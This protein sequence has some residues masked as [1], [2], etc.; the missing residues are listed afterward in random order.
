MVDVNVAGGEI[1]ATELE[2]SLEKGNPSSLRLFRTQLLA[3]YHRHGRSLPWRE[4]RD[5]YR[6]WVSEVMLQQTQVATV[7]PYYDR[8]LEKFPSVGDLANAP[9]ETVLR[10]WEGLGYYRRARQ[11][12]AAAKQIVDVHDGAFPEVLAEVR[13]LP[14]IGRYTAGAILSFAFEQ[15]VPILE[16]NTQRLFARLIA[17]EEIVTRSSAQERL[18]TFAEALLPDE[19]PG[20]FN[21]ALMELGSQVCIPLEPR[22]DE[23]PVQEFCQGR[24]R[25]IAARLPKKVA[26]PKSEKLTEAAVILRSQNRVLL[27]RCGLGERWEG[28]W[29]FPRVGLESLGS[30]RGTPAQVALA[31]QK[32][33]GLT[34][35]IDRHIGTLKHG[36]TRYLIT[37]HAYDALFVNAGDEDR[38]D[39]GKEAFTWIARESLQD[40]PL[41]T[42]GRLIVQ[43]I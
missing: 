5:P 13:A 4:T 18:W 20:R 37:L 10:V 15:R 39:G 40:L 24:R 30:K 36:V 33:Y 27:R 21:Q 32:R 16:A 34:I 17:C 7:L 38:A 43:W 22:C 14:G 42:T 19:A 8:F 29:D 11:M 41:S 23:C 31:I 1:P 9:E 26:P 6:I 35:T 25:G 3:W 28:L 2:T 12:H